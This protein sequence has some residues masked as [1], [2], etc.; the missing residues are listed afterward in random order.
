MLTPIDVHILVGIFSKLTTPDNVDIILGDMVFD[1]AAKRKRDIDVTIKYRNDSGNEISFVGI[2][3]KD[4]TRKLGSPEIEQLCLHF[5]DSSPIKKGG[6]VSASGFTKPGINK[7]AAHG[8]ELYE[9]KD[10]D[11][12]FKD[13]P[14]I[15]FPENFTLDEITNVF[16]GKPDV[17][18]LL[19]KEELTEE[20]ASAFNGNSKVMNQ[21][22]TPIPRTRVLS[23]LNNNFINKSLQHDIIS[24]QLEKAEIGEETPIN[25]TVNIENPPIVVLKDR[26]IMLQK[27]NIRGV[28]IKQVTSRKTHFKILVKLND[29]KYQVGAALTELSNGLL[30]GLSTSNSDKSVKLITVPIADRLRNKIHEIKIK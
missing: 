1:D 9:F 22:G 4:H 20:E 28:M 17:T 18:Y 29:P 30:M 14:H 26:Q 2:Q 19:E 11:H 27:V 16:V 23:D 3:V 15:R 13:L 5:K 25:V 8:I 7:A 12:S 10:W 6:I 21:D 24:S